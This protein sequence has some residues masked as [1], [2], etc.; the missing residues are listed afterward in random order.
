MAT[1][2]LDDG[3]LWYEETGPA[4]ANPLV[5]VHGGWLNGDCWH[6]QVER[7]APEYRVVTMDLRGHGRTGETDRS[8]Y[9]VDLFTDDLERLLAHLDLERPILGGISLGSM[10][11][12]TYLARGGDTTGAVLAGPVRS[13]TPLE[14]PSIAKPYLSP[15]PAVA[16]TLTMA[17]PV[18]TFRSLLSALSASIGSPWLSLDESVRERAIEDVRGMSRSEFRKVFAAL[19]RFD[20]PSLS[21]VDVPALVVYGDGENPQLKRQGRHLA[22]TLDGAVRSIPDAA[23]LV[24]QDNPAAFNETLADFLGAIGR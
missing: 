9:T 12:Q 8:R 17:G 3:T 22:E 11:V 24:N 10:V 1:L 6:E 14:I 21:G 7:F 2:Q 16:A 5:F 19:Y 20:P 18:A 15:V 4:D 23:H 13:M